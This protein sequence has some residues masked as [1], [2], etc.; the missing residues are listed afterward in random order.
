MKDGNVHI[1]AVVPTTL[2]KE[3]EAHAKEREQT[4]SGVV[5]L[6]LREHLERHAASNAA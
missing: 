4:L 3:V 5:R 2:R 1:H 6:A